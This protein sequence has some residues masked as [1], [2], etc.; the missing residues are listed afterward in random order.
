MGCGWVAA[1]SN[2][3]KES[4]IKKESV[5]KSKSK[6]HLGE[7]KDFGDGLSFLQSVIMDNKPYSG[8]ILHLSHRVHLMPC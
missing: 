4:E 7:W 2:L 3:W 6:G 1:R 8:T 5:L